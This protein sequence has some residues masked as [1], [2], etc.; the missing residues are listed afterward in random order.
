MINVLSLYNY[1][2]LIL[3]LE[4][5]QLLAVSPLQELGLT[6][7]QIADALSL[8]VEQIQIILST[9]SSESSN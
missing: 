9:Q 2:I 6:V 3:A 5:T 1:V 8:S 4:N 7:G